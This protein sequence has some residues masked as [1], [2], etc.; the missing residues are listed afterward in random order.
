M[1]RLTIAIRRLFALFLVR[2]LEIRLHDQN[3]AIASVTDADVLMAVIAARNITRR[4]LAK[5]R[6]DYQALLAPG[7]RIT[8]QHA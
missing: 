7:E 8:W 3:N 4:E 1:R 5:A 2:S 6:A